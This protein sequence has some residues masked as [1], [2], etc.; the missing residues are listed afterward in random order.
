[1]AESWQ[2]LSLRNVSKL[3]NYFNIVQVQ[4]NTAIHLEV[5]HYLFMRN[6]QLSYDVESVLFFLHIL[7]DDISMQSWFR[8]LRPILNAFHLIWILN[9]HV[10]SFI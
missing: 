5:W 2:Y 8:I 10:Q 1:M 7:D 6:W 9:M 4:H 3:N